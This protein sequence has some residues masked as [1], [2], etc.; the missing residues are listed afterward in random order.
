MFNFS[1]EFPMPYFYSAFLLSSVLFPIMELKGFSLMRYSKFRKEKGINSRFGMFSLYFIPILVCLYFA[2]EYIFSAEISQVLLISATIFHFGKRCLESL[3]LHRYS[4]A[5]DLV[6]VFLIMSM[7]SLVSGLIGWLTITAPV[8]DWLFIVG[9][10]LFLLGEFENFRHH[11]ILANL[12]INSEEYSIPSDGMFK[13]LVCP[14]YFYETVAWFGVAMMS[15]QVII[16]LCTLLSFNYLAARAYKTRE[17]YM[18][19]F[20]EFPTDRKLILPGLL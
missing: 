7:Y 17:W 9:G 14:H 1:M 20:K 12:R 13:Q 11:K 19:K 4:G 8:V 10:I 15:H 3:F 2:R 18:E 6:T 5:I 16:I